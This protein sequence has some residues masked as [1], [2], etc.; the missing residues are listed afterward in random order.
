MSRV[1]SIYRP[2]QVARFV[3][4][5]FKG[6]FIIEGIGMFYFDSGKVL[7]PDLSEKAKLSIMR[8][9]NDTIDNLTTA[10]A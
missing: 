4:T 8:E 7:L 5:L 10:T 1:F 3:K 9:V 6:E 2:V